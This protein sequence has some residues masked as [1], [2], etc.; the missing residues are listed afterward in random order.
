M[1]VT[2][3]GYLAIAYALAGPGAWAVFLFVAIKGR[4][5]L[6]IRPKPMPAIEAPPRVSVIVPC[7]NEAAGI[8]DCLR[9]VLA[10][11]YPNFEL[12]AVDD[13]SNDGT[14]SVIDGIAAAE[15]RLKTLHVRD[16]E[17]PA[18][19]LGKPNAVCRGV[20]ESGGEW[21]VFID[22]DCTLAPNTL[23]EGIAT[24]IAR[25]FDL[26]S[27][28]PRF[29]GSGFWDSLLTPLCGMATGGMYSMHWANA[30]MRPQTAFACGQFIAIKRAAYEQIGG[31]AALCD[32]AGEDVEMARRLKLAGGTP[33]VGWGMDLITT[34]MY[35]SL[36]EIFRGWGRNFI[37]AS[38]GR[39]WRVLAG[40]GFLVFLT[41]TVWPALIAGLCHDTPLNGR[42]WLALGLAHFAL[43]TIA[44]YDGYRWGRSKAAYAFL[45]PISTIFLL[46]L[47][48]RSLYQS[49]RRRV[50]WRGVCYDLK[51]ASTG[52]HS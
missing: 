27:F 25:G 40:I 35:A 52:T 49:S 32:S 7:R 20:K 37:A 5:R 22:S 13:R 47:F 28:V 3:E 42:I 10:Q 26:V 8:E 34:R 12:I 33:R 30:R 2:P 50:V 15:P 23:R 14:A 19:W 21:L 24:G 48:C 38:R 51:P 1:T 11:D 45:W 17:L 18:G 4:A 46:A 6:D 36:G 43:I 39:P 31:H 41:F 9:S 29:V 44:L 16:G